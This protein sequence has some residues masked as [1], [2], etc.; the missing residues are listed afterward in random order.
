M[1][2]VCNSPLGAG[3]ASVAVVCREMLAGQKKLGTLSQ[4]LGT[5]SK[6]LG[7][8]SKKLGGKV[9]K[10]E[11]EEE[12]EEGKKKKEKRTTTVNRRNITA[13]KHDPTGPISQ[14]HNFTVSQ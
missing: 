6:K 13:A 9:S 14:Y 2:F 3:G 5:L 8:L 11:G 7:T 4:N 10:K 1:S 12:E